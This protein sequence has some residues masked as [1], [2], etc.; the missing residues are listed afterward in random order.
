MNF[1]IERGDIHDLLKYAGF[2]ND[3]ETELGCHIDV[4][5]TGIE[6]KSFLDLIMKDRVVLYEK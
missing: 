5:S 6:D 4:V 1:L 3:L 2:I